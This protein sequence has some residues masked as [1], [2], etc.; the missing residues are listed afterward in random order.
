MRQDDEASRT[1]QREASRREFLG[2]G[3]A[4]AAGS[5]LAGVSLPQVHAAGDETIRLALIGCGGRGT[6]AAVNAFK[7]PGGPVKLWT[8]GD[9]FENRLKGS[10]NRLSKPFKEKVDVPGE[11]QFAGFDAY[12]KCIDALRPGDIALLTGY[13]AEEAMAQSLEEMLVEGSA[14]AAAKLLAD[15]LEVV[16]QDPRRTFEPVSVEAEYRHKTGGTVWAEVNACFL[17]SDDGTPA[18]LVGVTRDITARRAM[19]AEL[20]KAKELAEAANRAKSEFLA[21]MSHEIRTPLTAI[22]GFA[23]L[24][25]ESGL[26]CPECR[27]RGTCNTRMEVASHIATICGNSRHLLRI[28]NDILDLSQVEAGKM[29]VDVERCDPVRIADEVVSLLRTQAERK[30]LSLDVACEGRL[31]ATIESDPARLRQ[32]L[33][34]LLGNAVKFTE[35]GGVQVRLELVE[36]AGG[37]PRLRFDVADTGLGM[38]ASQV[39][40]LFQPFQQADSSASRRFGGTG[41][42]L[43]ISKRLATILCGSLTVTSELGRGSVFT[44][45]LPAGPLDGATARRAEDRP[46]LPGPDDSAPSAAEPRLDGR[47]LLAEDGP[48]NQRL[49]RFLLERAG[50]EVVV[51]ENGQQAVDR[52]LPGTEG[53]AHDSPGGPDVPDL[54]LMDIQMPVMDGLEA[55]RR[56]RAAGCDRPILALTAHAMEQDV[57]QC[58]AAGC[59][60][61][62][63]KPIERQAFIA[64]VAR[65]LNAG[66]AA[67]MTDDCCQP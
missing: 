1:K 39:A 35:S 15:R 66:R 59:D 2:W 38:S 7:A 9:L 53:S 54:V 20:A 28:I 67:A 32:I 64:T 11:R 10:L 33:F 6:G 4:V 48:D 26:C 36:A 22:L 50:A 57:A 27:Q 29:R 23:E 49:I 55:T 62:L 18:G 63:A 40:K 44:L 30:G 43:A 42:G 61:H 56:L 19:E 41:L 46:A 45:E 5:A 34:N 17:A 37:E 58:L 12:K 65:F 14:A 24:I 52:A 13:T 25:Q 21:N 3:G 60:A 16:R 47:I 8:M 51:V 31:P